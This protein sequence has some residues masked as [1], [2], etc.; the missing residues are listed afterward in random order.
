MIYPAALSM[1]HQLHV[2]SKDSGAGGRWCESSH[3]DL[4]LHESDLPEV[5]L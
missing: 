5:A 3:P 4:C 2:T 1:T